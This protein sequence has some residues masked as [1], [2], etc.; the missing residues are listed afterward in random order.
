ML[1]ENRVVPLTAID[2]NDHTF[3]IT[4]ERGIDDLTES[5]RMLGLIHAPLLIPQ[6]Q[7]F[8][9]I[10]GFRRV[11]AVLA[12]GWP[13]IAARIAGP[14]IEQ[15][16]CAQLAIADNA[17]QRQLNLIEL[18]RALVLLSQFF[19]ASEDLIKVGAGLGLPRSVIATRKIQRLC[20]LPQF[21]QN[22]IIQGGLSLSMALELEKVS[23]SSQVV[24][25]QI[26]SQLR[27]SLSKQRELLIWVTEIARREE[28]D[29]MTIL[30]EDYL[31]GILSDENLDR[32]QK[33]VALRQYLKQ[34]RFPA[35]TRAKSKFEDFKKNLHLGNNFKLF[36][37]PDFE[38]DEH[39][40]CMH[41]NSIAE[42]K[43]HQQTLR[44]L[45]ENEQFKAYCSYN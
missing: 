28:K 42:L 20:R 22:E 10:S 33:T 17:Q 12:L 41:F 43:G 26:F 35:L 16:V 37:P 39:I 2:Q 32:S 45:I 15:S 6:K 29:P 27:L 30:T 44:E 8:S 18:S 5:I 3:L 4:T 19:G 34:R 38:G 24:F 1:F 13:T 7:K 40:I 31:T 25:V 21:I 11:Q 36:P 14:Q 9:V 23:A